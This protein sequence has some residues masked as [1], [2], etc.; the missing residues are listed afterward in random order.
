MHRDFFTHTQTPNGRSTKSTRAKIVLP[1]DIPAILLVDP[2]DPFLLVVM[3]PE[4]AGTGPEDAG[5]GPEDAGPWPEDVG[6]GGGEYVNVA[7]DENR[8]IS[9][10]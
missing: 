7:E 10:G 5:T 2:V 1:A 6:G 8:G 3:G 9:I 4:D